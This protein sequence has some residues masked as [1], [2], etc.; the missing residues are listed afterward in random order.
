MICETALRGDR[1]NTVPPVR[2]AR[3]VCVLPG[4]FVTPGTFDVLVAEDRLPHE[5]ARP[6]DLRIATA[7][8]ALKNTHQ[9]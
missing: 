3:L 6:L 2:H 4:V 5:R 7:S 9:R 1:G 8:H